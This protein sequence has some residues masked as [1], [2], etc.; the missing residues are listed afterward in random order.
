M[1]DNHEQ[2]IEFNQAVSLDTSKR[3]EL[4]KNRDAL[5]KKITEYFEKNKENETKPKYSAQGSFMM[6]T[7]VNPLPNYETDD[8]GNVKT[9][10]PYDLDDGVYFVDEL[11]N[12]KSESTY[13][14]WI[15]DAV[16]DH[17]SKG[18]IKKNTCVR[19][20][21][22]DGHNIDLPIYFKEKETD[23]E[24]TIPQLAHKSEK[25][26]DSDP[27]EF[28]K[29]FNGK[30]N[31]QLKR[32]VRY[33]KAWRDKQNK[34]YN[35]KMPSGLILTILA[36]NHYASNDRD[37]ICFR[38]TLKEIRS[39]LEDDF[40]CERPTTKEGEGLLQKYSE[41]H[42]MDRLNKLIDAGD[43]AIAHDN[44][45]EGCKKWQKHLGDRFVCA[46]VEDKSRTESKSYSAPAV[47]NV[48]ATSA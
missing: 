19:V 18:A 43:A 12:R 40:I 46:N 11:E 32:L 42:F 16:K 29:W 24:K 38:D 27:R 34:S 44:P 14:N 2:F 9:L 31:N 21:Y 36:T 48:N 25:Y 35:T 1:A 47:I 13:H 8:D 23:G 45:K 5:R 3:D 26:V 6:H 37:D 7:I 28:Y 39:E 41:T 15:Y 20:L 17:T 10:Y 22:V 33:L 4:K 30:A